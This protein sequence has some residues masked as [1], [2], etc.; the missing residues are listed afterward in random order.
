MLIILRFQPQFTPL[1]HFYFYYWYPRI[2]DVYGE[3]KTTAPP[4][5]T[6]LLSS[7]PPPT[8]NSNVTN[9]FVDGTTV[10]VVTT[11]TTIGDAITII[12]FPATTAEFFR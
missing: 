2:L 7:P 9:A 3:P 6:P 1:Y 8:T 10:A 5:S 11:T 12:K 4:T